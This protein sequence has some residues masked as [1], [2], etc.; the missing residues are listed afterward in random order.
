MMRNEVVFENTGETLLK[1]V[2]QRKVLVTFKTEDRI[3]VLRI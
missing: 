2:I 1:Y 3:A